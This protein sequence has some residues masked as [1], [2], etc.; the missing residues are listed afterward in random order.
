MERLNFN[1]IVTMSRT[2]GGGS[3]WQ[4]QKCPNLAPLC[5]LGNQIKIERNVPMTAESIDC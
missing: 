4:E 3:I 1:Q 2:F 5:G